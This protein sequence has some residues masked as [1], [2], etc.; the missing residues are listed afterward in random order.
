[1]AFLSISETANLLRVGLG[2]CKKCSRLWIGAWILQYQWTWWMETKLS[3]IH[4]AKHNPLKGNCYPGT[5][6]GKSSGHLWTVR[7]A[8]TGE[9]I[10]LKHRGQGEFWLM[11]YLLCSGQLLFSTVLIKPGER[12]YWVCASEDVCVWACV[13]ERRGREKEEGNE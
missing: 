13:K 8:R 5:V 4:E 12:N 11:E 1:M 3:P 10:V 6:S 9:Q 7:T 2:S